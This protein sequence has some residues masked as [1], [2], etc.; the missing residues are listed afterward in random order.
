MNEIIAMS[1]AFIITFCM[2]L[3]TKTKSYIAASGNV[4]TILLLLFTMTMVG[5]GIGKLFG[6]IKPKKKKQ[7]HHKQHNDF[8][9]DEKK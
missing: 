5:F 8:I 6:M 9:L 7:A 2:I 3:L 4:L 1:T